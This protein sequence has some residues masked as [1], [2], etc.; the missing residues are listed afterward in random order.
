MRLRQPGQ[1][2]APAPDVPLRILVLLAVSALLGVLTWQV[3]T[4][5]DPMLT[6]VAV[7][8][9]LDRLTEHRPGNR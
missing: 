2:S 6:A 4:T 3:P 7:Y 8:A 1:P 9:V 5:V